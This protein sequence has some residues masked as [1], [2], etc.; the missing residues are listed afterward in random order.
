M[1]RKEQDRPIDTSAA[2]KA[3]DRQYIM[4]GLRIIVEFGAIIAVPVV[5]LTML[6]QK[7]DAVYGTRPM[8]LIAGFIISFALSAYMINRKAKRFAKDYDSIG[9]VDTHITDKH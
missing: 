7:L 4:L 2:Q 9:R 3:Q 8:F 1:E 5:L 6:G